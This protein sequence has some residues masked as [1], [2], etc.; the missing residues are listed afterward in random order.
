MKLFA[1][2]GLG[3]CVYYAINVASKWRIRNGIEKGVWF[4]FIA[5]C[6]GLCLFLFFMN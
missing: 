3:V 1:I 2:L 4:A 5:I 6:A